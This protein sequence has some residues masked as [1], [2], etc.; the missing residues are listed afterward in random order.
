MRLGS[1]TALAAALG[2]ALTGSIAIT[3]L[4][5]AASSKASVDIAYEEFTLPNG[6]RVIVHT[7]RKAP[8]VAV[9]IWYHVGAK[10]EPAG[11]GGFAHL[12]EHLMF[13]RSENHRD[14]YFV[15]FK[16]VGVTDQNG[17]TNSDRTNYFQ[18]VPTT[19]LDTALF[20][21]SDRMGYLL[22]AIDQAALDEQRG[23]VQNEKRQGENQPYGRVWDALSKSSYP[24]SHPYQHGVIGSMNDLNAASLEDVKTWFSSWYGPNNA[25]LVLAG[26]IDLKTAKQKAMKFFGAIPA[27]ATIKKLPPM[28]A[29][30]S[31][32]T[33]ETLTDRVPQTRIYKIWNTPQYGTVTADELSVLGLVLG[34]SGSSRLDKRLVLGD[35]IADNV[36]A[37]ADVSELGGNFIITA[38]VKEGVDPAKVEAAIQEELDKLLKEGPNA[39]ELAQARTVVRA[40]FIRGIER[41]GGFGG[42]ADV[43]AECAVYTGDAGCFRDSLARYQNVSAEQVRLSGVKWLSQGDHTLTVVKGDVTPIIE[44]PAVKPVHAATPKPDSK[45]KTVKS[46]L[47]RSAGVQIPSTFPSLDF[48]DLQRA[49]LSNG[50]KIVLAERHDVPVVQMNLVL[51]GGFASDPSGK[52]GLANYAMGML[53][54][55]AGQYDTLAF[56]S[57]SEQLGANL[58]AGAGLD[59]SSAFL[60][61][62]KENLDDSLALYADMLQRPR[63][64]AAELERVRAQ[65]LAGLQQEKARP[66]SLGT[67]ILPGL[68]FD[69]NHPYAMPRSG[70]GF[71]AAIKSITREDMLAYQ[72]R[73][74]RPENATLVVVGNTKLKELVPLLQKHLGDWKVAGTAPAMLL[75][76]N[77]AT[78]KQA[79]VFLIDQPGAVQANIYAAQLAPASSDPVAVK[80]EFANGVFGGDFTSRL[81]M[82]LREDKHWSYGAGSGMPNAVG[83][84]IWTASAGV[85]IDKTSESMAEMVREFSEYASGKAAARQDEVD[86]IRAI[87]VLSLPGSF[88]TAA[89][90]SNQV[91]SNLRYNRPDN[92]VETRLAEVNGLTPSDVQTVASQY[93]N[94]KALTWL[95]IGDLSKIKDKIAALNIGPITVLDSDGNIAK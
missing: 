10:D 81:N 94:P 88:E 86:R 66:Q 71:E 31:T 42:K 5:Q 93:F 55:G 92:Y 24:A 74:V 6:L 21:E 13:Q 29:A 8:I 35:K 26:D 84:R 14:E 77:Q 78:A 28:I 39:D 60:S 50:M 43:L 46:D 36:S 70:S 82:N 79:R 12:F 80:L 44:A 64:D 20:M 61:A 68:L 62:L 45:Y 1:T 3:P 52:E 58:G 19:A 87:Q 67:R 56:R 76:S 54:E 59:G 41:I 63:F 57:R 15:P 33:R 48:P 37:G 34:G 2:L 85:Q 72:N 32:S 23:V 27:S 83:Q 53:S 89:A 47:D 65:R 16:K 75:P 49:T 25:V 9:N 22:G 11:L 18:N 17:T 38:D 91:I 69:A 90:V 95:V 51:G 4:A 40:G 7:D 30:R 73:W